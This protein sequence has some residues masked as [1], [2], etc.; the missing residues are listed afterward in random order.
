[1]VMNFWHFPDLCH[2]V[3][4]LLL[5]TGVDPRSIQEFVG[6]EDITTTLG[7]YSHMLPSMQ[8]G[9]VVKLDNLFGALILSHEI[10]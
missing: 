4:T 7:I 8:Q 6:H 3:V 9:I 5:S 1:M 2:S 10:C